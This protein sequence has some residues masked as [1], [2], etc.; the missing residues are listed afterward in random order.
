MANLTSSHP[1][2]DS[3]FSTLIELALH[4]A[5][6]KMDEYLVEILLK[7]DDARQNGRQYFYKIEESVDPDREVAALKE[8]ERTG[9]IT[10]GR[11]VLDYTRLGGGYKHGGPCRLKYLGDKFVREFRVQPQIRELQGVRDELPVLFKQT[12]EHLA[13]AQIQLTKMD[14]E[15]SR[16][17]AVRDC[18]SAMESLLKSLSDMPDIKDATKC[19]REQGV[20]NE[21]L[22]KDGLTIWDHIHR[23]H[24][25]VRHG[26]RV[27][28]IMSEAE[29]QY[30]VARIAAFLRY[31][32]SV[33]HQQV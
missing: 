2:D 30:W 23:L 9:Y 32:F 22:I 8:L 28:S 12:L 33:F 5:K 3:A 24:P 18:L 16:K 15:R 31:V 10:C 25:D 4:L 21:L 19:L 27:A 7:I 17:D 29:A 13:Q 20:G 1:A 6:S 11:F 14:D 26:Q